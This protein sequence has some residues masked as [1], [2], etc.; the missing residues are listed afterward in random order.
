MSLLFQPRIGTVVQCNFMGMIEPEMV[1]KRDVVIVAR[2]RQNNKLVT[3]VPL[4]TT[5][6]L[7]AIG[8]HHKLDKN[9]RPNGDQS[10]VVWAK[11]DMIYTLSLERLDSY[12]I[13]TRKGG[14]QSVNQQVSP[15]DLTAIR[16]AI[17][18]ALHLT[19]NQAVP[20]RG[21]ESVS[22][23]ALKQPE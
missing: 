2:H 17:A 14:R 11:C 4:S 10:T 18:F 6:P 9:P 3:V 7:Q 21:L 5:A 23:S 1:K 20:A 19:D 22:V 15:D 12:Y 13:H 16:K 8:H